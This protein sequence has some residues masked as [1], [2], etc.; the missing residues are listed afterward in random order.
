MGRVGNGIW[1]VKKR[2]T[3]KIKFKKCCPYK[4]CLGHDVCS[5]Q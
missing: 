3:N 2:I 4:S 1:S 5:Q